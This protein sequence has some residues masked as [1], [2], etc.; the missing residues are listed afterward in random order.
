[1]RG[2]KGEITE[3]YSWYEKQR[4]GLGDEF[5]QCIEDT[6]EKILARPTLTATVLRDIRCRL[7]PPFPYAVYYRVTRKAIRVLAVLHTRRD[8]QAWISRN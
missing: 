4:K 2:V 6:L 1:R 5:A 7:L 8:P 3:A